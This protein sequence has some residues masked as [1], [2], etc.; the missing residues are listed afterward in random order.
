MLTDNILIQHKGF[1]PTD[2]SR[3]FVESLMGELFRESPKGSRLRAMFSKE[4]SYFKGIV[5][6]TSYEG[7]SIAIA[8]GS[9]IK[10]VA[11]KVFG[12]MR[13]NLE[14]FKNNRKA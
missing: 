5:Q 11:K 13:R 9:N 12:Q 1:K 14:K 10:E 7:P 4:G 3:G 6:L 8:S 2:F